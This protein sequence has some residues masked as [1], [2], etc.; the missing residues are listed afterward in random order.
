MNSASP[1]AHGTARSTP[2]TPDAR[3][4]TRSPTSTTWSTDQLGR[5]LAQPPRQQFP[6]RIHH[7]PASARAVRSNPARSTSTTTRTITTIDARSI[8]RCLG[9]RLM[10]PEI[11][12]ERPA[13]GCPVVGFRPVRARLA[14]SS[15]AR[16]RRACVREI[17]RRPRPFALRHSRLQDG[18]R[19]HRPPLG[20]M[21]SEASPSIWRFISAPASLSTAC[22]AHAV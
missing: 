19:R 15:R 1:I 10:K 5:S 18:K 17:R 3:S 2:G 8:D 11:A 6:P 14:H 20:Q 12:P 13:R 22:Y 21:E 9:E 4:T 7:R 16:P